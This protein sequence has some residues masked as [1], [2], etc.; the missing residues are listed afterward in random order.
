MHGEYFIDE[1]NA[2]F[3]GIIMGDGNI[4]SN[5]RKYE[6]TITGNIVNDKEYFDK[7][8]SFV[9]S[10]IKKHPYYRIRGRGLRLTIYSKKFYDF[11][12]CEVGI[13]PRLL[14][15]ES[16]I[17]ISI[18]KNQTLVRGFIRG[19]FDTDG[20]VFTSHKKGVS[21]YPTL[22]ITNSNQKLLVQ[23]YKKLK[24]MGFRIN[25]RYA[26]KGSYKASIYGKTMLKKWETDI[27]SSN[28]YKIKRINTILEPFR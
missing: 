8:Y 22:E 3:C 17:P 2:E 12:T 27:G 11:V 23:V 21:K 20:S 24:E 28:P 15:S 14:K 26:G 25:Y 10:K 7:L 19:L 18:A 16:G 13:P 4:W 5:E 9:D 1:A 6:V